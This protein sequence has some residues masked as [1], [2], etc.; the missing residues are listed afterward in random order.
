MPL[1]AMH[2]SHPTLLEEN[3]QGELNQS[4]IGPVRR[5][6]DHPKV[7]VVGG[8]TRGVGRS[9]LGSVEEVEEFRAELQSEIPVAAKH[10][11]LE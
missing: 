11:L 6:C 2:H 10:R 1:D 5:A 9:K 8:A 7:L 4:R 3:L